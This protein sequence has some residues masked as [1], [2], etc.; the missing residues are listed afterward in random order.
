[1]I[2]CLPIIQSNVK[3]TTNSEYPNQ[4]IITP[5][6]LYDFYERNNICEVGFGKEVAARILEYPH[7]IVAAYDG[8]VLIGL[9]RTTFDGLSA[10]IMEFSIGFEETKDIWFITLTIAHI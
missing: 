6:E 10:H 7:L 9:A 3:Y 8:S 2:I 4:P 5:N 1:M